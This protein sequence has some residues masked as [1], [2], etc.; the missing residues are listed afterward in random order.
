MV[1]HQVSLTFGQPLGQA[2]VLSDVPLHHNPHMPLNAPRQRDLV[3][4]SGTNLG[5]TDLS[6]SSIVCNRPS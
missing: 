3:A 4:K 5:P 1:L 2:D 6:S